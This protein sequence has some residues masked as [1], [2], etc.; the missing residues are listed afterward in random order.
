MILS[1][2]YPIT[3]MYRVEVSGWDKN[4]AFF[5]EKSELQWS[6]ESGKQVALSHAVPDGA[7]VFLRLVPCLSTDRSHPVAYE[8]EFVETT[9]EG[10]HQFRLHPVS[11]RIAERGGSIN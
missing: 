4:Q 11:P 3:S 5:V 2:R 7:V 9:P 10:K 6:A 8:T 1:A